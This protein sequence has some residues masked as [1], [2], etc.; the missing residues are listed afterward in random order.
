MEQPR[1][2]SSEPDMSKKSM[3]SLCAHPQNPVPIYKNPATGGT[4]AQEKLLRICEVCGKEEVLTSDE[5]FEQGWD[6]LPR[7]GAFGIVSPRTCGSCPISSKQ[8]YASSANLPAFE[9]ED[10][11]PHILSMPIFVATGEGTWPANPLS[12]IASSPGRSP[13]EEP[14]TDKGNMVADPG[15]SSSNRKTI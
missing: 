9:S 3:G 10:E 6:Y 8:S 2:V 5:A 13:T 14:R 11:M 4:M 7:M 15:H 1:N 12:G